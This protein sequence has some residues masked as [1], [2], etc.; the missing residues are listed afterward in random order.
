MLHLVGCL[1]YL[2]QWCTVKQLS[3]NE[4]NLSIK[5]T[6]SVLCRVAKRL[7]YIE[8]A[9]CLKVKQTRNAYLAHLS[10]L[11]LTLLHRA[12]HKV[13]INLKNKKL[14]FREICT[15]LFRSQR[16]YPILND[17]NMPYLYFTL[18]FILSRIFFN[19]IIPSIQR[20]ESDLVPRHLQTKIF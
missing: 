12:F 9:Q 6:K 15:N 18:I 17:L 19:I 7:S 4:I 16:T 8:E 3:D 5:Y 14:W 10:H 20:T 11:M 2:Y 13:D 1:Y